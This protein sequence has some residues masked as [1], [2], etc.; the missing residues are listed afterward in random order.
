LRFTF[1]R[2]E[3]ASFEAFRA[4]LYDLRLETNA[5]RWSNDYGFAESSG[6]ELARPKFVA[7]K[8]MS[9][10]VLNTRKPMLADPRIRKAL[11]E[12]FD[13]EAVNK[14]L[15]GG[16]YARTTSFFTDSDMSFAG[17]PV[18]AVETAILGPALETL[19]ADIRDGSA[20]PPV[21]DGTGKDRARLRAAVQ[22]LKEAGFTLQDRVMKNAAGEQLAFELLV[23]TDEHVKLGL[24]FSETAKLIGIAATVRQ[25][26][27]TQYWNSMKDFAFDATI[28]TYAASGSPGNEQLNRWSSAAASRNG[29]LNYAGVQS[30]AIDAVLQAMLAAR[31]RE[32][33]I[34]ALR[35]LDRLLLAG[36][37]IIPF[38]HQ[39]ETWMAVKKSIGRPDRLPRYQ[40]VPDAFWVKPQ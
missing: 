18:D 32:D 39:A 28:F 8:G 19:P 38:Y 36:S 34:A 11:I 7:P 17:K 27:S 29:S 23:A 10:I 37:Y 25:V 13:F 22:A 1:Y 26:E 2:D 6:V 14:N 21:S 35:A 40:L 5:G 31:K 12:L 3:N 24:A 9:G 4:G 20:R 33:F 30:P 15:F 16:V